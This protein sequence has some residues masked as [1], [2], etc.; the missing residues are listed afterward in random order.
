MGENA[1]YQLIQ[2]QM[3][4]CVSESSYESVSKCRR[5]FII[6]KMANKESTESL[7]TNFDE[8]TI[9][10]ALSRNFIVKFKTVRMSQSKHTNNQPKG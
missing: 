8:T 7:F 5:I 2:C 3:L 1:L 6:E 10:G 9:E 4:I